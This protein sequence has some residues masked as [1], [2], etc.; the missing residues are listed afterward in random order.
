MTAT[1]ASTHRLFACLG[2]AATLAV[3]APAAFGQARAFDAKAL[4]RYDISYA[5]C[6]ARFPDM[7]GHRDEAYLNLWRIRLDD[8]N[9]ARLAAARG[10]A[11]YRAEQKLVL[12]GTS[13]SAAAAA[14][15]PLERECQGLW[16]EHQRVIQNKR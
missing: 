5:R 2:V 11:V 4:A 6:E 14:S 9:A 10:G 12:K 13:A 15:A 1:M 16:A 3:T 7:R 8:K